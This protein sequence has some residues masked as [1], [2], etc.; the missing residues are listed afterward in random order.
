M[1]VEARINEVTT[2]RSTRRI[3]GRVCAL[4]AAGLGAAAVYADAADPAQSLRLSVQR[5]VDGRV[6]VL[7]TGAGWS[8]RISGFDFDAGSVW[9]GQHDFDHDGDAD[10]VVSNVRS[11]ALADATES[12][13]PVTAGASRPMPE[14]AAVYAIVV[15]AEGLAPALDVAADDNGTDVFESSLRGDRD[16]F[17]Y[18]LGLPPPCV[19]YDN[20]EPQD[21]LVFDFEEADGDSI[22]GWRH[23]FSTAGT[24]D[25]LV[26][27]T[28]EIFSDRV[29]STIDL[30]DHRLDFATEPFAACGNYPFGGVTRNFVLSGSDAEIAADG[31]VLVTFR[32][33]DDDVSVEYSWMTIR[34]PSPGT[35]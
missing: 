26:L 23:T 15:P 18:G 28:A 2:G 17:G 29:A 35:R 1:D 6:E 4:C 7:A 31:A 12:P 10:I 33:N 19:Y 30:D 8:S 5:A 21:L 34:V 13:G 22:H 24:P 14:A 11:G 32:E 3:A 25:L 16:N 27:R 20:R 9:L